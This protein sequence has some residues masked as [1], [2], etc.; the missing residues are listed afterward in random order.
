M[1]NGQYTVNDCVVKLQDKN[2][3]EHELTL[4]QEVADP[5]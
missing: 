2:R 3:V 5:G 1:T 4:C